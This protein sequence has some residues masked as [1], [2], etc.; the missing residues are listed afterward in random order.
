MRAGGDGVFDLQREVAR[1]GRVGR[2][3]R[4]Q[5]NVLRAEVVPHDH[6]IEGG[7]PWNLPQ[8]EHLCVE[9]PRLLE[10]GHDDRHVMDAGE[11]SL[12]DVQR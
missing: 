5:V 10:V 4:H 1:A 2:R 11:E 9:A 6:E 7:G 8:A 12:H 3:A